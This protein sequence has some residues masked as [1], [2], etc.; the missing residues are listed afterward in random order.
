VGCRGGRNLYPK[1]SKPADIPY[2][3]HCCGNSPDAN[4]ESTI[5]MSRWETRMAL[6]SQFFGWASYS[7]VQAV[8]IP[9][10]GR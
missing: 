3:L 2:S 4:K 6:R 10:L 1:R 5:G 7:G 8:D 9:D